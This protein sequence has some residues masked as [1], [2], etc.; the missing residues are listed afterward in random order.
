MVLGEQVQVGDGAGGRQRR[1]DQGGRLPPSGHRAD[2]RQL[3][4][5]RRRREGGDDRLPPRPRRRP[6]LRRPGD[7]KFAGHQ[8][9]AARRQIGDAP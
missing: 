9:R 7:G 1:L 8:V 4:R 5:D 3:L 2:L 6:A